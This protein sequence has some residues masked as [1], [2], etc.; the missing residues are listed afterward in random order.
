MKEMI[1]PIRLYHH[2]YFLSFPHPSQ[3]FVQVGSGSK[4]MDELQLVNMQYL[5][6][7]LN[8]KPA[9]TSKQG[10][11]CAQRDTTN[12]R[13]SIKE[14]MFLHANFLKSLNLIDCHSKG[15]IH[16]CR[17]AV[18]LKLACFVSFARIW[19]VNTSCS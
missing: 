4:G 5:H 10:N 8:R 9:S 11:W 2:F 12:N 1:K 14:G 15:Y 19:Q 6:G 17:F 3:T 18:V 7:F 16:V 13:T